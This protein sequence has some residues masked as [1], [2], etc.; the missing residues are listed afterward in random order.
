LI[1]TKRVQEVERQ[2]PSSK[3]EQEHFKREDRELS[4]FESQLLEKLQLIQA[5][6]KQFQSQVCVLLCKNL[7]PTASGIAGENS[8]KSIE[9]GLGRLC[10]VY[11]V[12][13]I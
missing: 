11:L 4:I 2:Q 13:F 1:P 10:V 6:N 3:E 5:E 12:Y 8:V 9:Q 7:P